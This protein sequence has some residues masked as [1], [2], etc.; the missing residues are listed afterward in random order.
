[1]GNESWLVTGEGQTMDRFS[2]GEARASS[3]DEADEVREGIEE[4]DDEGVG[5]EIGDGGGSDCGGMVLAGRP[6]MAW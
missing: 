3:E 4:E 1:M 6:A 2:K 5:W